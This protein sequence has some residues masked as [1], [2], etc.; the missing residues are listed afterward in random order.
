MNR[1]RPYIPEHQDAAGR[2]I[3]IFNLF[4]I[5]TYL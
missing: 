5:F 1:M 3:F 4:F 2:P